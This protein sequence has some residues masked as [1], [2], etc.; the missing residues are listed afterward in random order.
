[1]RF[2]AAC[3]VVLFA[4][5]DEPEVAAPPRLVT[6][7][8][9]SRGDAID[10]M[11]LLG[12]VRGKTEVRVFSPMPERIETLHV[13]EGDRVAEG[14]PIA[15]LEA[16]LF[17]T[18]V[19]QAG[20][21][22]SA[23]EIAR[24]Q[25]STE[26]ERA[27]GL[28]AARA[29]ASSQIETLESRLAAAQ[30]QVSQL[31]AASRAAGERRARTVVRAPAAGVIAEL[32]VSEGDVAVPQIPICTVVDLDVV[33]IE[34]HPIESDY[35]KL[36]SDLAVTVT[37]LALPDVRRSGT[38][39][40]ISPV[41]DRLT[42]T[43]TVEIEVANE[44]AVMRPGMVAEASFELDRRPSV[45]LVPSRAVVLTSR[46]EQDRSAHV[47]VREGEIAKR[48]DVTLGRRYDENTEI[49]S[50]LSGGEEVI[51]EGHFLLRDGS[52][53][54]TSAGGPAST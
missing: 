9:V 40:R 52:R 21:A 53:I 6:V 20:A 43:A 33:R 24:D 32:V 14:D 18:D 46:S 29:L 37:P 10:R 28:V 45:V 4:C 8:T 15:T 2:P 48:L 36:R 3:F 13:R 1:M 44:G 31:R 41:L 35:V 50:G 34:T 12:E 27:R 7:E 47:F 42:R 51:V 49:V 38:I 23:A 39:T 25:L 19:A 22:L 54:R 17:S 30:A 11:V 16:D 5:E 26:L